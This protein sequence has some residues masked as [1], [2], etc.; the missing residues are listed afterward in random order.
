MNKHKLEILEALSH[1]ITEAKL[2]GI[3]E[4]R[5]DDYSNTD[6]LNDAIWNFANLIGLKDECIIEDGDIYYEK[7]G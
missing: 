2:Y 1:L 3:N 4:E 7:E 5:Y 6:N